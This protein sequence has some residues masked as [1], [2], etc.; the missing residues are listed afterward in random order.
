MTRLTLK[1][2]VGTGGPV[3]M[4]MGRDAWALQQLHAANE[5]GCTPIDQPA[6]RWSAYIHKLR[7]AGIA[8]E[9]IHEAHGGQFAGSHGRYVLRTE[10]TILEV[11]GKL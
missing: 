3:L 5:S 2:R 10:I 4:L 11:E 6:P 1:V 8:I 9:T 7:K